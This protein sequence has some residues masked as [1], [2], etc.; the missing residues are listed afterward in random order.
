MGQAAK[1]PDTT[2][3][4]DSPGQ[5]TSE[6]PIDTFDVVVKTVREW[7]ILV[8]EIPCETI[9]DNRL[10]TKKLQRLIFPKFETT[11]LLILLP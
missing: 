5:P 1:K 10:P 6:E 2:S 9:F 7:P 11:L 4:S 8:V 3:D